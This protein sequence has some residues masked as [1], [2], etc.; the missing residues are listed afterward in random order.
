MTD[1]REH[2]GFEAGDDLVGIAQSPATP[3]HGEPL[4][5]GRFERIERRQTLLAAPIDRTC[6][7]VGGL[8][9]LPLL[10]GVETLSNQLAS[11]LGLASGR[12][13]RSDGTVPSDSLLRLPSMRWSKRQPCEPP[14]TNSRRSYPSPSL[15]RL[16][17]SLCLIALLVASQ[18]MRL[19]AIE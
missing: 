9:R 16:R 15:R 3:L 5:C 13:Q 11:C 14:L 19:R 12:R 8:L 4:M 6:L 1:P 7:N 10:A 18:G 2:I 17:G